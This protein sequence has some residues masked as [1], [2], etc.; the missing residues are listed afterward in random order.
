MIQIQTFT[1]YHHLIYWQPSSLYI[2]FICSIQT[3]ILYYRTI[4]QTSYYIDIILYIYYTYHY[5]LPITI[6]MHLGLN[7]LSIYLASHP[8]PHNFIY[9][10]LK[11]KIHI[12]FFVNVIKL[13]HLNHINVNYKD[14]ITF[15]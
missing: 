5:T 14:I 11:A 8:P 10:T 15:S 3:R 2:I 13:F 9:V 7:I 6:I 1:I 12:A 4:H